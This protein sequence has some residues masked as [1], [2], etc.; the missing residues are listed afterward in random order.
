MGFFILNPKAAKM[1]HNTGLDLLAHW[2]STDQE[3]RSS[4][5]GRSERGSAASS[6]LAQ[7]PRFSSFGL[8]RTSFNPHRASEEQALPFSRS[9]PFSRT[10]SLERSSSSAAEA[11]QSMNL[12]DMEAMVQ[13]YT[14][15]GTQSTPP[16]PVPNVANKNKGAGAYNP[17]PSPVVGRSVAASMGDWDM[18][19]KSMYVE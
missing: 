4:V 10:W 12:E 9:V 7:S 16:M 11:N 3:R 8:S 5:D 19:W 6:F 18:Y 13:G 15:M 14:L 2:I 1:D 17:P